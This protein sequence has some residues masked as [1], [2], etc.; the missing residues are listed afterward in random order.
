MKNKLKIILILGGMI[1]TSYGAVYESDNSA[2]SA[3]SKISTKA[4]NNNQNYFYR[5]LH[6][7]IEAKIY[8][9]SGE[10]ALLQEG[11]K[12][13]DEMINSQYGKLLD[14]QLNLTDKYEQPIHEVYIK[15]SYWIDQVKKL[16]AGTL[17]SEERES[18]ARSILSVRSIG[19]LTREAQ[20]NC[21][22]QVTEISFQKEGAL[23]TIRMAPSTPRAQIGP[24]TRSPIAQTERT[25]LTQSR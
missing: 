5:L 17:T 2:S 13:Y 25:N 12:K 10:L 16:E 21:L 7:G 14:P 23:Q 11:A 20:K 18:L 9:L 15:I 19:S 8:S 24:T 1:G 4:C 3:I 22:G 6:K